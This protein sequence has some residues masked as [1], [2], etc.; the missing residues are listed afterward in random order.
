MID[1]IENLGDADRRLAQ[2]RERR[3]RS[4]SSPPWA[5]STTAT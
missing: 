4:A 2:F 5:P 1:V 3:S